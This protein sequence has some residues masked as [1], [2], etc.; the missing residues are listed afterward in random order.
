MA[1][2]TSPTYQNGGPTKLATKI[3]TMNGTTPVKVADARATRRKLYIS[4]S[5]SA[6]IYL[7]PSTVTGAS[8][9]L[10]ITLAKVPVEFT[11][12]GELWAV[13]AGANS[14]TISVLE[15]YD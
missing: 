12:A 8:D 14:N 7:G 11:T 4:Q 13:S 9:G 5:A 1:E 3:T 2:G 15:C 6:D 10:L